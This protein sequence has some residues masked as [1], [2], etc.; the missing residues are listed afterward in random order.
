MQPIG[1]HS[2]PLHR[3]VIHNMDMNLNGPKILARQVL[4]PLL[5]LGMVL[6]G[7]PDVPHLI[8]SVHLLN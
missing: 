6:S 8:R 5:L 2:M 7:K 3:I 4:M 1:R